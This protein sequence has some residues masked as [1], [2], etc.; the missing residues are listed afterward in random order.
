MPRAIRDK[1]D[2]KNKDKSE[3]PKGPVEVKSEKVAA[4]AFGDIDKFKTALAFAND[5]DINHSSP[6]PNPA[7]LV[8]QTCREPCEVWSGDLGGAGNIERSG[9]SALLSK[10]ISAFMV[11]RF[12]L[13]DIW[14]ADLAAN[15]YIVNDTKWFTKFYFLNL[16]VNTADKSTI[17][18]VKGGGTVEIGVRA[19]DGRVIKWQLSEIAY[20]LKG[21]CNLL[22]IGMLIE[23]ADIR[24]Y[25]DEKSIIF[26]IKDGRD[27]G[28]AILSN[29]LYHLEVEE[30]MGAK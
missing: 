14:L 12:K 18:E 20:A 9:H 24:G 13:L 19:P 23:K 1:I 30:F 2:A 25:F 6:N 26:S 11:G 29:G 8:T 15:M 22:S 3:Q 27:V 5:L 28:H 10:A 7:D 17:L 21:R 16:D 4:L